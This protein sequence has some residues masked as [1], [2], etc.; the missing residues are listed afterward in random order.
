MELEQLRI[1]KGWTYQELSDYMGRNL[2][3]TFRICKKTR[4]VS[5]KEAHTIVKK[6]GGLVSYEDLLDTLEAC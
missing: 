2:T 6:F 3:T 5:L 4:C 1:T